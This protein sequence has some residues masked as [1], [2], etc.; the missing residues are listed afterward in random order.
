MRRL[1]IVLSLLLLILLVAAAGGYL[2]LRQSLPQTTGMLQLA[3]LNGTVEIVRDG[4]GVPHIFASTDHDAYFALG[5]VHAQDR[6]WQLEMSRRI[7]NGRLSEVLG[8]ATLDIDKFQRTMGYA[9]IVRKS[10][11]I[12]EDRSKMAL[13][14]YADGVNA[15]I[16]EGHVLPP[17]FL[18][19]G[20]KPEPWTVYDSLVWAKMM[21]WDLAGDYDLELLRAKLL[22]ALGPERAAE[23]LPDYPKDAPTIL[24]QAMNSAVATRNSQFAT[25]NLLTLASQ[26]ES[27]FTHGGSEVGSNDWTIGGARTESGKPILADDPHLGASIPSVWYLAEMQGDTLHSIGATFPGLPAIVIGHNESIAWGVTNLNPDVQDLYI[28]KINP[29]NPNQYEVNGQWQTMEIAEEPILVSGKAEPIQWAARWTRH[30]PLISDVNDTT[31]PMSMRWTALAEDDT[32]IDAFIGINSAGNWEEFRNAMRRFVVPSQNFVY[33]DTAG[34]IGYFGPGRIPI[35]KNGNGYLPV[36]GWNDDY[37][38]TGWIPFDELPQ[39]YNPPQAFVA[40]ANNKVVTD[41]YPYFISSDWSEPYRAQRITELI[42]T[43]SKGSERIS[44]DDVAAI[45]GDQSSSEVQ[46]TLPLLLKIA[47]KD[48]R[49]QS[50]LDLLTQWD[51]RSSLDSVAAS[52]YEAWIIQLTKAMF[53]DDL[54]GDLYKEMASRANPVFVLNIL[55]DPKTNGF[56]CDNVLTATPESCEET[57]QSALD[58]ALD[59]LTE[60]LGKDMTQWQWQ[61][62]HITQYPHRPFSEVSALKWLFHRTIPN[63]GNRYTVNVAPIRLTEPYLQYHVPSYRQI[64]DMSNLNNSRFIL[65]TGQSGN[66]LSPHYDDFIERHRDV[67]YLPMHFGRENVSGDLLTLQAQK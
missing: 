5:Y 31:T 27:T 13:H 64:V 48:E 11:E 2:Y 42:E 53:E 66:L 22:A 62:L 17:E 24:S 41:D 55:E 29:T 57:L 8:D 4:D 38:W 65:T 44:L 19:L 12:I 37:E 59:D 50:A 67:A 9:R 6:M 20:V 1:L 32:T 54:R 47:A 61:K 7:G 25:R 51:R 56:W 46:R 21:A 52:I 30:G 10:Y 39:T 58:L 15:W 36:P 45:H 18:I 49:Q 26:L 23:I 16:G 14:A 3:G 60:R 63:G 33:A 35:R 40:T 28:E 43:M 34:N